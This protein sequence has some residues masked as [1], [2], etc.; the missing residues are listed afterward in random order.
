MHLKDQTYSSLGS[1]SSSKAL[2]RISPKTDPEDLDPY[3]SSKLCS[4]S[5]SNCLIDRANFLL[6]RS[7]ELI[8]ASIFCPSLYLDIFCSSLFFE[9]SFL[10]IVVSIK[11][12]TSTSI[13]LLFILVIVADTTS[14]FDLFLKNSWKG[15]V[16]NCFIPK[17]I[18]SFSGSISNILTCMFCPF[19]YFLRVLS[20][21]ESVHERS[22]LW[23][24]PSMFSLSFAKIPNSVMFLISVSII[25][26][27]LYSFKIFSQGFGSVCFIPR[28]IL[29][30]SLSI[31]NILTL[32]LNLPLIFY[33][34]EYFLSLISLE[35][36]KPSKSLSDSWTKAP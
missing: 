1:L 27:F 19:W 31:S 7:I 14:P 3:F 35:W 6:V 2:P 25:W 4:S 22:F 20:P 26:S 15:S 10:L 28:L 36:T 34:D 8:L 13:P 9:S 23:I 12:A 29:F 17:L 32:I 5:I 16:D 24:S 18:F 11:L 30:F 21:L 33:L